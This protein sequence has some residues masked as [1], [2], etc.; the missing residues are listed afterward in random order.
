LLLTRQQTVI[1][2]GVADESGRGTGGAVG[3]AQAARAATG[4]RLLLRN[5]LRQAPAALQGIHASGL[6]T[7]ALQ[8]QL[9]LC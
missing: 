6:H 7:Q 3:H 1:R 5:D 4:I 2:G 9:Q 8:A